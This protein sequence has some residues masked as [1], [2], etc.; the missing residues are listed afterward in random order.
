MK[1][2]FMKRTL[3]VLTGIVFITASVVAQK[4][5][6]KG[7]L[8]D[9]LQKQQLENATVS[10]VNA[11][12]SSLEA[13]TRTDAA[14]RFIFT[15]LKEG[16]YRLSASMVGF[17]SSWKNIAIGNTATEIELGDI[18][19]KDNSLLDEVT[20][21]NQRPPV[22][23]NGD[24]LEFNAEAFKTKLNAVVEDMLKK[25]P[26]VEVAKDGTIR[27][28]GQ[29]ISRVYV[30]GKEFFGT[31]PT[32]AT[33]NLDA[34]A[35]DKV[36]V[37]DKKSDQAEFTGVDDGNSEKA[38]NLKLKKDRKNMSFGKATAG[39]GSKERFDGQFNVNRFNGE[40]QLSAIGMANNTNRQGFTFSDI[41][42]FTGEAQRMM[43][44]GGG[45]RIVINNNGPGDFGLPVQGVNNSEG[46]AQTIAGGVNFNDTWKKKTSVNGSY[47]YNNIAVNNEKNI[48]RQNLAP[49]NP[50]VYDQKSNSDKKSVGNR[51]NV[52]IDAKLDSFNSIKFTPQLTQQHNQYQTSNTYQSV[53]P[54][55]KLLN[56]GFSN[57]T[58]DAN[59]FNFTGNLLY[60]HKFNKKGRTFS[61]NIN[62]GYNDTKSKGTLQSI[63][64]FYSNGI[65]YNRDTL[66]QQNRLT[67]LTNS[68]GINLSYTEPISKRL[69]L[70]INSFYNKSNGELNRQTFDL[71]D[72]NGKH[73][74]LNDV[75][76][77]TFR[78][79]YSYGGGGL[80]LRT[81]KKKIV[82][83]IGAAVQA[84]SLLSTLKNNSQIRQ[85]FTNVLP[86]ANLT[87][88]FSKTRNVSFQ[89]NTSTQQ[90]TTAQLQPVKDVSDP[91]NI[92]IGNPDLKQQYQHNATLNYFA[93]S[94]AAQRNFFAYLNYSQSQNAIVNADVL[95]QFGARTTSYKNANGVSTLFAGTETGFKIKK[96]NTRINIGSSAILYN[97]YSF[98]NNQKNHI[99]NTAIN[100]RFGLSYNYKEKFDISVNA[101]FSYNEIK[102]SLQP[103]FNNNYWRNT[104]EADANI[105]LPWNISINNDFAYSVN[106]GRSQGY[107]KN[108]AL[109]NAAIT[110]GLFKYNRASLKLSVYDLLN[111]NIGISRNAN[112]NYIEDA[113]YTVLNRFYMMSFTYNLRKAGNTG[114]QINV[115][116]N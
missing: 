40:Q 32:I 110:K 29:R 66:D 39:M 86:A 36:Q 88:N 55:D 85:H 6:L 77:N 25:M 97:N 93:A 57:S 101:R 11:K 54:G 22:Q 76:S 26:G 8:T 102:Y 90:P 100:P 95:D 111:Q 38:I 4:T 35:L 59:G 1:N 65:I 61:S 16:Q 82:A 96:L 63:N 13:F 92:T 9:S 80:N 52:T 51:F 105:N 28:N 87:Y 3:L 74:V 15:S 18:V 17:H 50:F 24:T 27:V 43:R 68:Y 5:I 115:R 64:N 33:R 10:L 60:R 114:P 69:L 56:N 45:G 7:R 107:N 75:L 67:S 49:A 62:A 48:R 84:A 58:T 44:G 99:T 108:V 83:G 104:Y 98:L 20:V 113:S 79:G 21:Q 53:L 42:N 94:P 81:Q 73:D 112:L 47:F 31:D 91:L 72:Q 116:I 2:K 106:S 14:G 109:W 78:N 19:M 71:N 34:D 23:V 37:F 89:Y 12:D 103:S 30:N 46:I 41:L 70:E